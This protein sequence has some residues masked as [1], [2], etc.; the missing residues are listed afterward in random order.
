[1]PIMTHANQIAQELSLRAAQVTAVTT[2]LDSGN[3]IPF[4]ARYRKEATGS[5]D[6]EQLRAIQ[7]R[8]GKLRALDDRRQT[9]IASI[10]DQEKMTPDLRQALLAAETMTALE[11]L[12]QPYKP[13]RRTRATIAREKGLTPLA[14]LVL[15]QP[16]SP[17]SVE[18]LAHPFLTDAAPT[19]PEALAGAYD[20]VAETIS[21]NPQVRQGV[22]EKALKFGV[23]Q[24]EK[25]ADAIDEKEVYHL[26]YKYQMR[27]DRLR[28]H[29]ILAI[30]RGEAE[31]I[32]RVKLE[33]SENDW[34]L[35]MRTT[36]RP[37]FRHS[38][39]A[40]PLQLC[41]QDAAQRLL[42]PAIERDVRRTLTET[43]EAHAIRVFADN[44][45]GLLSQ[46][47]L[48][49]QTILALDPGFR[50][51]CKLAV[52]D[53]TGK[54]LDSGVIYPHAP[55][56]MWEAALK[57]LALLINRHHITLIAIGNGTASRETEKLAAE[58][59]RQLDGVRYL[60]VNEAGASIYSA[61]K[62]AK[63][64]LPDLDVTIRG[65][66]SIGR[67]VQDPLAELVKIDPK[68]I[69]VGMYQHDVNQTALAAALDSV[70]ESV[71]NQVGV[72]VNTASPALLTY[73]SGIGPKLAE[74]IV[75]YRDKNGRFPH[76]TALTK[77][78][79]LGSKAFEQSAGFLRIRDG[80][81]PLDASAIHPES[82]GVATA[83]LQRAGLKATSQPAEREPLL[84]AL[85]QSI[86]LADLA[87]ELGT[88]VP[89]LTDIFEQLI[90]PGRDPREDL[91]KPIL[92]NDVLSMAD[93]H[94]GM[95]LK[96]TVRNV[97]DFG[98]FIDIGVKQDGLLH[99]S[100][101]PRGE[102]LTVGDVLEVSI[103]KVEE[104]RGRISLGWPD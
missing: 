56:K 9:I 65:A 74:K 79:G 2:L 104:D 39:F 40:E 17:K 86:S 58:L 91:P 57:Q 19:V 1:M 11:D 6:E 49:D 8:T 84:Q 75:S 44:L 45:R 31:K 99:R 23:I 34:L 55:Q 90:R 13:K 36:F 37:D 4:I 59:T 16:R 10:S 24:V 70:V 66:A 100:Q 33:V 94:L 20:I 96:G 88:G 48:A 87:A 97:V 26:Y 102:T 77:V 29:Q 47:P 61:S 18:E 51:G 42:L 101:L 38:P 103:L 30:N 52:I 14:D 7:E 41:M 22:R 35:P 12:Y 68:S 46:P 69:G 93:L 80:D 82:Y 27:V 78:N 85:R 15:A 32:V 71:V 28:P 50:T 67:R 76:R 63:A 21:D 43:A 73:V 62:L 25:V 72:D 5:L 98:A 64:E 95:R 81:E 54:V 83:V 53:T 60:L 3:T 92:R 89:T